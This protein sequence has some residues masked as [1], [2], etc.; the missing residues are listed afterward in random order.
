MK[1]FKYS[2]GKDKMIED[3]FESQCFFLTDEEVYYTTKDG[4]KK[5]THHFV[6]YKD[7]EEYEQIHEHKNIHAF[8]VLIGDCKL[9]FDIEFYENKIKSTTPSTLFWYDIVP[10]IQKHYKAFYGMDL[11][12]EDMFISS[13]KPRPDKGTIKWSYHIVINNGYFVKSNKDVEA[14]VDYIHTNETNQDIVGAV[15]KS[16]YNNKQSFKLPHQS[17]LKSPDYIQTIVNGEFKQHLVKRYS[18]D[19]FEGYYECVIKQE[20]IE[21]YTQKNTQP[22]EPTTLDVGEIITKVDKSNKGSL[23]DPIKDKL[24]KLGNDDLDW[25]TYFAVMCALKNTYPNIHGEQLFMDWAKI[26]SKFV[27]ETSKK[28]WDGLPPEK[29]KRTIK[30]IDDLLK[31][32]YPNEYQDENVFVDSITKITVNLKTLGYDTQTV[33]SRYCSDVIDLYKL[34]GLA[35][36]TDMFEVREKPYRDVVIKSHLGTGKTSIIKNILRK[37]SFDSILIISPRVMFG[38]SIFADFLEVEQLEHRLKF[39][40]DIKKEERHKCKFMVCQLE[41]LTTLGDDFQL[42]ILDEV[43]SILNQFHSST[44]EKNFDKITNHFGKIMNTAKYVISA[45]A[46]ITDRSIDVLATMRPK[47]H[48]IYI[49]NTFNPYNR[50]CYY[51]GNNSEKLTKCVIDQIIKEPEDRRVIIT[52][53]RPHC[54]TVDEAVRDM[55]QTSLKIN[56]FTDDKLTKE[57][58]NVNTMWAKYQNVVHTS[59]ITVGVNY[60]PPRQED[61]FD[62]LFINFSVNGACVRDMFQASLRPRELKKNRLFYTVYDRFMKSNSEE[63]TIVL[64]RTF[65]ELYQWKMLN[66]GGTLPEW[67][68]KVWAYNELERVINR[69]YFKKVIDRYLDLCGY[70][71]YKLPIEKISVAKE[72]KK[73][74]LF[75]FA[76]IEVNYGECADI[77]KLICSGDA[78]TSDKIKYL[79]YDFEFNLLGVGGLDSEAEKKIGLDADTLK[80]MF[81]NYQ[82]N[83]T[84]IHRVYEGFMLEKKNHTTVSCYTDNI[85]EKKKVITELNAVLG[86]ENCYTECE[87]NRDVLKGVVEYIKENKENMKRLFMFDTHKDFDSVN[88]KA[89]IGTLNT[90]Y[91]EYIGM[92]FRFGKQKRKM[93]KGETIDITP[94]KMSPFHIME[95]KTVVFDMKG[96]VD[97]FNLMI[98]TENE[99]K[100]WFPKECVLREIPE[101]NITPT[102]LP[103]PDPKKVVKLP[104]GQKT[105][106]FAK[107][108]LINV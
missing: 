96:F 63:D 102:P 19:E 75:D 4:Q 62:S 94:I 47:K 21:K 41:S 95:K 49:E 11:C 15:D 29:N 23:K 81:D 83:P 28:E 39:Y 24:T 57:I 99:P 44:M 108:P 55:G 58:R 56:R 16:P 3:A 107:S 91:S 42:V 6:H 30:T 103:K 60:A 26:S 64:L 34:M 84:M 86:V 71:K 92:G 37:K 85:V 79:K 69:M 51:M 77:Y 46:F 20:T 104:H 72:I 73:H 5:Q 1:I 98:K 27:E 74:G 43:E 59:T 93:V 50:I 78:T 54:D 17:K 106:N 68:V 14:F 33:N 38:N 65:E 53:S 52:G 31:K 7:Y 89:L 13:T 18:H 61:K 66:V 32:K 70:T 40:K 48:K 45:D 90:I 82:Q 35:P 22:T 88:E 100:V 25:H 87:L 9:Y 105:L 2:G 76:D 8:E 10:S 80:K 101:D 36:R 67:I 97:C 12:R